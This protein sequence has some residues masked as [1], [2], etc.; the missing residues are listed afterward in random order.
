VLILALPRSSF[1]LFPK[2]TPRTHFT[3]YVKFKSKSKISKRAKIK[4]SAIKPQLSLQGKVRTLQPTNQRPVRAC[5]CCITLSIYLLRSG[6]FLDFPPLN[7]LSSFLWTVRISTE[8]M[9]S[10][11]IL[12]LHLV[13]VLVAANPTQTPTSASSSTSSESAL[14][15]LLLSSTVTIPAPGTSTIS[16]AVITEA[17][18]VSKGISLQ[19]K[20]HLTTY[21][22]CVTLG[23]YVD[24]GVHEP[25]LPGGDDVSGAYG[26]VRGRRAWIAVVGAG[27]VGLLVVR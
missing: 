6:M 15:L 27:V 4:Q 2:I 17:P 1:P 23:S 10:F 20:W 14:P 16:G 11:S 12:F 7:Y 13:P 25:V 26:R 3:F 5:S 21:T 8:I 18:D 22:T 24:C 19:E 9:I